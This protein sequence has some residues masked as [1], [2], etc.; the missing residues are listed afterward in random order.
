EA[1]EERRQE[2]VELTA[3]SDR[4]LHREE[5]RVRPIDLMVADVRGDEVGGNRVPVDALHPRVLAHFGSRK[6]DNHVKIADSEPYAPADTETD[7]ARFLQQW[8]PPGLD[9]GQHLVCGQDRRA[10]AFFCAYLMLPA[11]A[12]RLEVVP[13]LVEDVGDLCL[14]V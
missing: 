3:S 11:G 9:R 13:L 5:D 2:L 1:F 6:I 14:R 10:G 7:R 8:L 12:L 4:E